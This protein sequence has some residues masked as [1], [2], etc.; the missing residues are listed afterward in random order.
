MVPTGDMKKDS[1]IEHLRSIVLQERGH[2]QWNKQAINFGCL[3]VLT[4]FS[5]VRGGKTEFGFPKCSTADWIA[6]AIF[7][8]LMTV[9]VILAVKIASKEQGLKKKYGN[10]NLVD[11]DLKFEGRILK[12]ILALGFAGGFVAGG[13]SIYNPLLLSMGVPPKVSSETGMYLVAFSTIS[14]SFIFIVIGQMKLDYSLWA[15][16]WSAVG[17][18]IGLKMAGV[19]MKKSG[20]QSIIVLALTVILSIAV[21]GVP[22]F[23]GL[24]LIKKADNG[25]S[26]MSFKSL[27]S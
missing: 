1:E 8:I 3:I 15:A 2:G 26:I 19:Y 16:S 14:T 7:L 18:I 10:I 13:G 6:I 5:F 11:S 24:D 22:F 25:I 12:V 27:C 20:R 23:G 21:V 17:A 4:I 9:F